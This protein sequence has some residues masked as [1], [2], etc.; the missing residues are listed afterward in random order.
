[1]PFGTNLNLVRVKIEEDLEPLEFQ[2][3]LAAERNRLLSLL[4]MSRSGPPVD[5][6]TS[7]T[8]IPQL[9]LGVPVAGPAFPP[10]APVAHPPAR[11][12]RPRKSLPKKVRP[13]LRIKYPVKKE[14]KEYDV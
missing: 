3:Q 10:P 11:A 8:S 2:R 5:P 4:Y 1:M 6:F 14:Y 9:L 12:L 13:N 7:H